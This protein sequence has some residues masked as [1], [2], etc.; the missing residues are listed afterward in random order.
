MYTNFS[1]PTKHIIKMI[2]TGS[3]GNVSEDG[4]LIKKRKTQIG[5]F[6]FDIPKTVLASEIKS[7]FE[8]IEVFI[9]SAKENHIRIAYIV[10][11]SNL[12]IEFFLEKLNSL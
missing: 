12:K 11:D 2:T 8:N 9:P 3:K 5:L 10:F 6:I 4:L 1:V 7:M